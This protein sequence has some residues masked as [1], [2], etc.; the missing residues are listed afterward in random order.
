[1][2]DPEHLFKVNV[3][4]PDG[5]IYSHRSSIIDMRAIDGQRAIMYDHTPILTP[6]AIGDV[7]VKR[8]REMS[9]RVDHIAVNGGYLEFSNNVATIIAD[10]AE[11]ASNIDVSRAQAAK[12]RAEK[13]M[14][15]AREKHDQQSLKRA[16]IALRRAANRISVYNTRK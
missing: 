5:L 16:E 6:L 3:V 13:H 8:S 7:K 10:S 12:E 4:T 11:R 14:Q 9:G 2:A 15:E 1:M